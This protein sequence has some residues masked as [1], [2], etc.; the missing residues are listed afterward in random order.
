MVAGTVTMSQTIWYITIGIYVLFCILLIMTFVMALFT[1]AMVFLRAK[2]QKKPVLG[3]TNRSQTIKFCVAKI[4]GEGL[5]E[6][7][8]QPYHITENSHVR[9]HKSGLP[10]FF[11]FGEFA[12][13]MPLKYAYAVD[14]MKRIKSKEGEPMT[15]VEDLGNEVGKRYNKG[16]GKWDTAPHPWMRNQFNNRGHR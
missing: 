10:L 5:L 13:T 1:P 6:Y 8:K 3:I 16:T 2:F 11:A 4:E 12:A 15:N 14:K 7:N 9:E